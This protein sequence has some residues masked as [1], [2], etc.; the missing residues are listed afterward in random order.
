MG[1][2][3]K[4]RIKGIK[5]VGIIG[6]IGLLGSGYQINSQDSNDD[7]LLGLGLLT[8]G[9]AKNNPAAVLAGRALIDLKSAEKSGTKIIYNPA[10]QLE[11]DNEI[12]N[13][14]K[15]NEDSFLVEIIFCEDFKDVNENGLAEDNEVKNPRRVF[16]DEEKI[17]MLFRGTLRR[18]HYLSINIT[19][20]SG[21]EIVREGTGWSVLGNKDGYYKVGVLDSSKLKH[22]KYTVKTFISGSS[23]NQEAFFIYPHLKGAFLIPEREIYFNDRTPPG[24][25]VRINSPISFIFE[26]NEGAFIGYENGEVPTFVPQNKYFAIK[27]ILSN[28][29]FKIEYREEPDFMHSSESEKRLN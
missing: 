4:L 29:K 5:K 27:K 10:R 6:M 9:S 7:V 2:I 3:D 23:D 26:K 24:I 18:N 22:G 13:Q 17:K 20:D 11:T 15:S 21:M 19:D 25:P 14:K 8:I 1:L 12:R 28:V 16:H